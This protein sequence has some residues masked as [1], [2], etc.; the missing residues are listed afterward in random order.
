MG[1]AI[2]MGV[3]SMTVAAAITK[4]FSMGCLLG[5]RPQG[6]GV[7]VVFRSCV[8]DGFLTNIKKDGFPQSRL[9]RVGVAS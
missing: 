7:P 3:V 8:P 6:V 4:R 5:S 2:A 1:P 9:R